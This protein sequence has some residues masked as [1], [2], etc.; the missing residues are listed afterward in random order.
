[1]SSELAK[2]FL[3]GRSRTRTKR[4]LGMAFGLFVL[5]LGVMGLVWVLSQQNLS[6]PIDLLWLLWAAAFI[7][8]G[9]PAVQAYQN[10]GLLVS[11]ALGLAIPLA[12]YLILT[13]FALVY[14]SE[15][16]LWGLGAAL[17]YGVPAGILGFVL[18]SGFRRFREWRATE[19]TRPVA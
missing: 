17:Q 7:I 12:F 18:G 11:L 2:S 13:I 4:Y 5:T 14:P 16:V 19:G 8:V 1:M 9:A 10:D 6:V 15:D 3:L